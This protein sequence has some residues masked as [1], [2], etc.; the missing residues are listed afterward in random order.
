M[1]AMQNSLT[2]KP[3]EIK[4]STVVA[5]AVLLHEASTPALE[6]ALKE[7]T[8]GS[9]D[10]LTMNSQSLT[11]KASLQKPLTGMR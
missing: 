7:M 6:A 3:I 11:L 9:P 5:V 8:A 2:R 4:I 1:N 10:F